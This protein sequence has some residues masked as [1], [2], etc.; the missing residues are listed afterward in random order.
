MMM[1]FVISGCKKDRDG[2]SG[3]DNIISS[4]HL[5][6]GG[7]ILKAAISQDSI[8]IMVPDSLSLYGAKA[9]IVMS[10]GATISPDPSL[11]TDWDAAQ[12]FTVKSFSGTVK[13]YHYNLIRKEMVS[14]G[15]ISL[16]TQAEIDAFG[17]MDIMA[18]NG[19]LTIGKREGEDSI[20]SLASLS[21]LKSISGG[22]TILPT[23]AGKNLSGL[24]KLEQIGGLLIGNDPA[25]G[26]STSV[27]LDTIKLPALKS[28]MDN[29]IINGSSASAILF[30]ELTRIDRNM[31]LSSLD[32]LETMYFPKLKNVLQHINIAGSYGESKLQDV[33][34]PALAQVGGDINISQWPKLKEIKFP[35][36][37]K[38]SSLNTSNFPA[39]TT[40]EA[41]VLKAVGGTVAI[42]GNQ[43]LASLKLS[44][45]ERTGGSF[46][47]Q[48]SPM[49]VN[50]EGI[51]KLSSVGEDFN[52]YLEGL[53]DL[54]DLA[55]LTSI[56][57]NMNL[58]S[59]PQLENG[60]LEG[61]SNVATIG[62]NLNISDVAFR[63]FTGF[64]LQQ[65]K[66]VY[67]TGGSV[68]TIESI[69]LSG[70]DITDAIYISAISTPVLIKGKTKFNGSLS[71]DGSPVSMQGFEEVK[72]LTFGSGLDGLAI[73]IPVKKIE[74][75]LSVSIYGMT[76]LSLPELLEIDGPSNIDIYV[77]TEVGIPKLKKCS[78]MVLNIASSNMNSF[79]LPAL[80]T[81]N[82]NFEIE[83]GNYSGS[84]S[85]V[86]FPALTTVNGTLGLNGGNED[87]GNTKMTNLNGFASLISV[88]GININY[89]LELT[90]FTGLKNAFASCPVDMWTVAGNKYNPSYQEMVDGKY[91][92]P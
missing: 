80:E 42:T 19:S 47:L 40:I 67:I 10:E 21:S 15:D 8:T 85:A 83:T 25:V 34:F 31:Q 71:I 24:D 9:N 37:E 45:L 43:Q 52:L 20:F 5:S 87:Y 89:N 51:K 2:F 53:K 73:S 11:V 84:L 65:V 74:N 56:G 1:F 13:N 29:F 54:S 33:V 41:P 4:F 39:L 86:N 59:L 60:S 35:M 36:L 79:S 28:V 7:V 18:L 92:H 76:Q 77:E 17:A 38:S 3:T 50:L 26:G 27:M 49:L 68:I 22:L 78:T 12:Q 44:S 62:G 91:V 58:Q 55:A 69:D 32:S 66:S 30:P 57:R 16:Y 75:R 23:Y 88:K 72:N 46:S 61:L 81:V 70:I 6:K 90:D 82:G 14:E 48:N 64:S 63:H